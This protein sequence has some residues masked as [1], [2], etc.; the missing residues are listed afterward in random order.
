MHHV[1]AV[2]LELHSEPNSDHLTLSVRV[3]VRRV[4]LNLRRMHNIS[5]IEDFVAPT[6]RYEYY[7]F[8]D[9]IFERFNNLR[10]DPKQRWESGPF[11]PYEYGLEAE[12]LF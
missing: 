12:R 8:G 9:N 2:K 1:D 4:F 10:R 6:S 3:Q 7:N 5:A 11:L